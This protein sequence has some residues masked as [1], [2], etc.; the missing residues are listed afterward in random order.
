MNAIGRVA[1]AALSVVDPGTVDGCYER[2]H[3]WRIIGQVRPTNVSGV[4]RRWI[5]HGLE[6]LSD[7]LGNL[8]AVEARGSDRLVDAEVFA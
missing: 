4:D 5:E 2:P 8:R 6:K 7:R 1:D 3:A